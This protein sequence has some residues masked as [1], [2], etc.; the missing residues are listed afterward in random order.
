M[1]AV[2]YERIACAVSYYER[3][4]YV[5]TEVPWIV[6]AR[7][8]E[9]TKPPCAVGFVT[10]GGYLVAS[11]EQGFIQLLQDGTELGKCVAV[12]PCFRHETY[13]DLHLPYFMKVEL[14]RTGDISDSAL[15]SMI[16]E[17]EAFFNA[18]TVTRIIRTADGYDIVD[19]VTGI[20]L[21][22]YGRRQAGELSWLYGT[23]L[24]EPRLTR[25]IQLSQGV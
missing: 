5:L 6:G 25:A 10:L 24:A 15:M 22:S 16:C 7:A 13:D 20:E 3:L 23:G 8:Y 21:G 4:G 9:V 11:A 19:A 18:V 1:I 12:T 17:A 2:N 14:I